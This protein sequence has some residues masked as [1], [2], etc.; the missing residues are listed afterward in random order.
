MEDS[1]INKNEFRVAV[2]MAVQNVIKH[3]DTDIFPR[4]FESHAIFDLK[5]GFIDKVCEYDEKFNDYL[6]RFPPSNTNALI[7]VSYFGFRWGTQLDPIWNVHFLSCV[8][9]LSSKIEA[10]RLKPD[11]NSVFSYRYR[12]DRETG[13]LF[14][15][16]LGWYSF[17][18]MSEEYAKEYDFVTICDIGEFYPRVNHHR[19][20]N[21][22]LQI[23]TET[24]YPK[25]IM[26]F[27]SNFSNTRS[28]GLPVGGPA[29]RILS[30]LTINQIDRLLLGQRIKFTR[31]ADDFHLFAR[32]KEEA[33]RQT[34]FISEK[35]FENQGLSLQKSKTRIMTASEF[36]AT[37]PLQI[38]PNAGDDA[39]AGRAIV[40]KHERS[41]RLMRFS[42]RFDP[43]S[44]TAENDYEDLKAKIR[45][46]D[47]IELL[48]DELSKSRIH[49]A[50]S[51]KL[52]AAIEYLD[53]HTRDNAVLSIVENAE[54]LYPIF[55]SA[56]M[57]V[58][59]IFETLGPEIKI[60]LTDRIIE[61]IR[62]DSHVFRVDVHLCFALRVLQHTNTEEIQQLLKDLYTERKSDI[63]RRDII[64]IMAL[65]G[66]WYWLSD[67]R[68]QYR[69]LSGPQK[70][71]FLVASYSLKDEGKHWRKHIKK[72]LDPFEK[73]ILSWA[74]ERVGHGKKDFPL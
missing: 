32:T 51:R 39:E 31:F 18:K 5:S 62:S 22:L 21:A 12:P 2:E 40:D 42:L 14:D 73:F 10:V 56:L 58:D 47:I 61:L 72:E 7:P 59:K 38:P 43:Y 4:S 57:M 50:L 71:S 35:L 28:F 68:N 52:V 48:Q 29:A 6:A 17:M 16:Q 41:K 1:M 44:P 33:Y 11:T 64:L 70:R 55:S 19:L 34:I 23:D 9:A 53:G 25:K 20:E 63:V 67:L 26:S 3:G 37:S 60:L 8:I 30:E 54:I 15:R 69:Q 36:R 13:D 45:E 24:E 49:I 65:W 46:F 74:D 27:L 66:E